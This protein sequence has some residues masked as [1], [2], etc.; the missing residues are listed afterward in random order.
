MAQAVAQP[1]GTVTFLFTDIEGS[2]LLVRRL[3]DR[4][5]Q[6]LDRHRVILRE[7]FGAHR[8]REVDTQGDSFFFAFTRAQD[9]AAAA[10]D[11]QRALAAENWP[12]GLELRV[13]MGLNTDEPH[14]GESGYH[15]MGVVRGA[16][17]CA[18]A[19]G[20]QILCSESTRTLLLDADLEGVTL[21]ELGAFTLKGLDRQERLHQL[22][23]SGLP[24]EFTPVPSEK[25][26][27][28]GPRFRLLGPTEVDGDGAPLSLGGQ[29]QK[30]VIAVLLLHA[31]QAVSVDRLIEALWANDPPRTA[32]TS[33]Q[34][35]VS[36]LRR[37]LGTDTLVRRAP[38]YMLRVEPD[39][40]DMNRFTRLVGEARSAAPSERARI[41]REALG[42]WRGSPLADFTYEAFAQHDIRRLEDLRLSALELENETELELGNHAEVVAELESLVSQNP[43]R[44]RLRELQMLAL[45]RSGRQA[46]ALDVYQA[47]RGLLLEELGLEPGPQLQ[48]LQKAIIRQDAAL[49][50]AG[51]ERSER[52]EDHYEEVTRA[53]LAGRV[54][55]V[56]GT[57]VGELALR[58]AERFEYPG[59]DRSALARVSQ[60]IAVMQGSGPLYDELH[61]CLEIDAPPTAVHRFFAALAPLLRDRG[62][63]HQLFVTTSYDLALEQALLEAGEEFDVVTY[64]ATGR[65]RGRF[66]HIAP[67]GTATVIERP[68]EYVDELSLARR[69][70][71][72]KLHGQ[73]DRTSERE[74]ESFVVTE[75]DYID[76][77]AQSDVTGALPVALAARL[78][79]SH[80]L[81]LGYRMSDWN[82]R[83]ILNRL[84]GDN[85]L[86]YRSWAVQPAP[87]SL[88]REFWR[89]RDVDVVDLPLEDYALG[90]A[91][92]AG[93]E[94][95]SEPV[96]AEV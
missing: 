8:G 39:Q 61:A 2:T 49:S 84:W 96:E 59:D 43:L 21:R 76:Y 92:Y 44:E 7:T 56:L 23:A 53:L 3:R 58:L 78:R 77:L 28:Q 60:Y 93:L 11:G 15:G 17:I 75:D 51:R 68:N 20:G 40:L 71:V 10:I 13:R 79:R 62:L 64:L 4:Y 82:L 90:L 37:S 9:A 67:N 91:R 18:A 34:N 42:L 52:P 86:N 69:S 88:E 72:L 33:L 63:P 48:E 55:P 87:R 45:Y 65:Y 41:L 16:R 5:G 35:F 95:E 80:F 32:V 46:E 81:F 36:Q 74:W 14:L 1:S 94:P 54:V 29:K 57:E 31:G 25:V 38:G 24:D 19:R 27:T 30:T 12:D 47:I 89:R 70:V 85:P 50:W 73:V 26:S 6:L 83:V 22:V 66:C